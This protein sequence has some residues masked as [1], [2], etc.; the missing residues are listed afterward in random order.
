M[1]AHNGH[2]TKD[3]ER[4]A[5]KVRG[6]VQAY[7]REYENKKQGDA[8]SQKLAAAIEKATKIREV[9]CKEL[10][11]AKEKLTELLKKIEMLE[12]ESDEKIADEITKMTK[13]EA[14][15]ELVAVSDRQMSILAG[16]L[17]SANSNAELVT[18][19]GQVPDA[20]TLRS[21]IPKQTFLL[22][23][24]DEGFQPMLGRLEKDLDK[25]KLGSHKLDIGKY[26]I[27]LYRSS[28]ES[29]QK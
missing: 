7:L 28:V 11:A 8:T 16:S 29:T 23:V 4:E 27:I 2:V 25:V 6:R 5:E 3:I 10:H 20:S 13:L 24:L 14:D 9:N 15:I 21:Q 18:K 17:L 22:P 12:I 1:G 19:G 26:I